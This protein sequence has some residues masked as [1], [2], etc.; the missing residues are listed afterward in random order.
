[1]YVSLFTTEKTK[2]ALRVV[3]VFKN[4]TKTSYQ[5]F[6]VTDSLTKNLNLR[7]YALF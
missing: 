7:I 6:P 3:K 2:V 5:S 1:M 4:N